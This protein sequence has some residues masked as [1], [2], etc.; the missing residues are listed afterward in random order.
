M[1]DENK[2]LEESLDEEE[3]SEEE[4]MDTVHASAT[5]VVAKPTEDVEDLAK[6]ATAKKLTPKEERDLLEDNVIGEFYD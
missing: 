2:K 6:K 5:E 4:L 1:S 3:K